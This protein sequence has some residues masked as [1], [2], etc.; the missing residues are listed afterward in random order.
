MNYR[1]VVPLLTTAFLEQTVTTLVRVTISYR[2]VELGLPVVWLGVIT[3]AF[4]VLPLV[5]AVKIGRFIDR[6]NDTRTAWMGGGL[7]SVAC[8]GLFLWQ[9]LVGLLIFTA[10]LGIGHLLLVISQ[11]VLCTRDPTPGAMER[12]IGNYMVANAVGQGFGPYLVGWA[13][14]DASLPPTH[15]LFGIGFGVSLLTFAVSFLLRAGT[16]RVVK[17]EQK[18]VPVRDIASIPGIRIVFF[19]SIV[20]VAAQDLIVVYLPVLGA[21]RGLPV[22]TVGVLLAVRAIASMFSRFLFARLNQMFGRWPLLLTSTLAGAACYIGLALPLPM[23]VMYVAIA[24]A[25]FALGISVTGSIATLLSLASDEAR[26]TANSLRMMGNR[27]G[28]FIIPFLA[29][30]IATAAGAAGIFL[31]IGLSLMASGTVAQWVRGR[32]PRAAE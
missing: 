21:E 25:G 2:A 10:V 19:L 20:T 6:G 27:M 16:P 14:G 17:A 8:A 9:S 23:A 24:G 22:D 32:S 13:G 26:G 12:M 30:L 5:F 11:Q 7:M 18:P 31:A 3:A 1:F 28:Q 29:G 4:A 15:F